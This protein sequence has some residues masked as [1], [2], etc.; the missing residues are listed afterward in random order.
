MNLKSR[1][2]LVLF[3]ATA[4]VMA[5]CGGGKPKTEKVEEKTT[6]VN[7]PSF[8]ADSAYLYVK[9]QCDFGPRVNNT[10]AHDLCADYLI[11]KFKSFTPDVA[12]QSGKLRAWNG[13][14]LRFQNI[15]ASFNPDKAARIFI[16]AHWDSRPYADQDPDAKNHRKPIIGANDGASGVGVL[17]EMAR[18]LSQNKPDIGVD[19]V[20]FDAEDYGAPE[21]VQVENSDDT[22][23]LG[24]Q[25]WSANPHKSGYKPRFGIL[26][27][28]VGAANATFTMEETSMY[29]APDIMRKVWD[30]ASEAGYSGYFSSQQTGGIT[31]D[32]LYVNK[33]MKVPTIDVI[34]HD[35]STQSGFY[36]YWHTLKD[37]FSVIDKNTLKAVGQTMLEVI[38]REK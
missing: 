15:I 4:V 8:N 1:I 33:I 11:S 26:L 32:H 19:L 30:I 35:P 29:Y 14:Y 18:Q 28:M 38:Y 17:L 16:S 34:Q 3:A 27:D 7:V 36:P 13:T 23:A 21:G 22:W 20:L 5:S 12:V 31:D 37:D 24:A 25:Y 9:A 10:K 6:E 2:S